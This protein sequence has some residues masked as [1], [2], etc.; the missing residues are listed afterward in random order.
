[1][2]NKQWDVLYAVEHKSHENVGLV[3]CS[4]G[5]TLCYA[6]K[7]HGSYSR[8][9]MFIRTHYNPQINF[10]DDFGRYMVVQIAYEGQLI[11]LV[12]V[13]ASNVSCERK[14]L[15]QSP[16]SLLRD[17]RSGYACCEVV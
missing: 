5:Y 6:G 9:V 4:H 17:G 8:I 15:W 7:D 14:L 11:W 13:Y 10:N 16:A 3:T 2:L 1:M 12:G